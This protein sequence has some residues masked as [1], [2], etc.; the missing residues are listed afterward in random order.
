MATNLQS[1]KI[2][3]FTSATSAVTPTGGTA[4]GGLL[5][6]NVMDD[7]G[8]TFNNAA[9]KTLRMEGS[10]ELHSLLAQLTVGTGGVAT[11]KK[12]FS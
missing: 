5:T 6:I 8:I 11:T 3:G 9:G 1:V 2:A 12:W 7:G 4:L 10:F